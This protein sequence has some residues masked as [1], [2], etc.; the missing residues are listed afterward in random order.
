MTTC[1]VKSSVLEL[2]GF[3]LRHY[4]QCSDD[5]QRLQLQRFYM[6]TLESLFN[7]RGKDPDTPLIAGAIRGLDHYLFTLEGDN[8]LG[9]AY[10]SHSIGWIHDSPS[11]GLQLQKIWIWFSERSNMWSSQPRTWHA[12]HCPWVWPWTTQK[13]N[14]LAHL[15]LLS[16]IANDYWPCETV[17]A[18][19]VHWLSD[20]LLI[21]ARNELS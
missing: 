5:K 15:L 9:R 10:R 14:D 12:T 11:P 8:K 13:W 2:L 1:T 21:P 16:W 7:V 17:A 20:H 3:L 4:S 18:A 19:P 6:Q